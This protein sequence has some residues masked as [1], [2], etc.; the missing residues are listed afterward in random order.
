MVEVVVQV[1]ALPQAKTVVLVEGLL[2]SLPLAEQ[3]IHPLHHQRK[4]VMADQEQIQRLVLELGAV[5]GL[6]LLAAM[7]LHQLAGLVVMVH[8]RLFLVHQ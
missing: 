7:E 4:A 1:A 2:M 8:L 5:V 6:V 3:E